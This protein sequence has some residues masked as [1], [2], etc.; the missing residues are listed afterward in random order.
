MTLIA[1]WAR[2]SSIS[3]HAPNGT[4]ASHALRTRHGKDHQ[5]IPRQRVGA[6]PSQ[7]TPGGGPAAP[8]SSAG[9]PAQPLP[10]RSARHPGRDLGELESQYC[11]IHS[12]PTP[13]SPTAVVVITRRSSRAAAS[14]NTPERDKRTRR[15]SDNDRD[16]F[17]RLGKP[18]LGHR[19]AAG[20]RRGGPRPPGSGF[21]AH[22]PPAHRCR[23]AASLTS[24]PDR[25]LTR[26]PLTQILNVLRI[27]SCRHPLRPAQVMI[28]IG[29]PTSSARPAS[30]CQRAG[31][32]VGIGTT[33]AYRAPRSL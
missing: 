22:I 26:V 8:G 31:P 32:G 12:L 19:Q 27:L 17:A 14:G 20:R 3:H 13:P 24:A 1:C 28:S 7:P 10:G 33:S 23:T 25:A 15:S 2:T 11:H 29:S 30:K 4:Q 9:T 5:L 21:H 6:R 18:R 16:G